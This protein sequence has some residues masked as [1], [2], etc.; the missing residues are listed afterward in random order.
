MLDSWLDGITQMITLEDHTDAALVQGEGVILRPINCSHLSTN[1]VGIGSGC[2]FHVHASR[3]MH[4]VSIL[5][6]GWI[7]PRVTSFCPRQECVAP[8]RMLWLISKAPSSRGAGVPQ[9]PSLRGSMRQF[10]I[11]GGAPQGDGQDSPRGVSL[12][13]ATA[14]STFTVLAGILTLILVRSLRSFPGARVKYRSYPFG[15]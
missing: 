3:F 15:G 5:S 6:I 12:H 13:R 14:P 10:P 11:A 9:R 1:E 7:L 2:S 8:T 4:R